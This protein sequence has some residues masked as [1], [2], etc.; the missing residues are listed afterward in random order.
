VSSYTSL[1]RCNAD[2]GKSWRTAPMTRNRGLWLLVLAACLGWVVF[3]G[4]SDQPQPPGNPATPRAA[5]TAGQTTATEPLRTAA[6]RS[7]SIDKI[8]LDLRVD[9]AKK[10]VESKA[11]LAFHCVKPTQTVNL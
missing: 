2:F 11:T 10:T 7:I 9:V 6:D 3:S 8:R 5:A 1:Q 4:G